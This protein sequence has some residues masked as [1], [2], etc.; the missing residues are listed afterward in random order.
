M[1]I[2]DTVRERLIEEFRALLDKSDEGVWEPDESVD[3]RTLL[4]ELAALRNEIR[5]EARQFKAAIDEMRGANEQ[6]RLENDRLLREADHHRQQAAGARQQSERQ[7]LLELL[8]L[9]DRVDA[10]VAVGRAYRASWLSR[11]FA[12]REMRYARA[13]GEGLNLILNRFDRLLS[14]YRV[15][16]I[17]VANQPLD[18]QCM[19]AV[20]VQTD[21]R[22]PD[23][24]V[25]A[26][27]RR[28][29]VRDGSVLRCAEVIVNKR[30][31]NP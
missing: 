15:R 26:E 11:L 22:H 19:N 7:M 8:D 28:G 17:D 29:F 30:K 16:P 6:L 20:G 14:T 27:Q 31:R 23:G 24:V 4:S 3:L 12:R 21:E 10:G 25:V 9:R 1:P 5:L 18:P 13:L 2:E